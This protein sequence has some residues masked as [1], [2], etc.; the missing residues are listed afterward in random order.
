M[1]KLT[2][3]PSWLGTPVVAVVGEEHPEPGARRPR[4][5]SADQGARRPV[6]EPQRGGGRADEQGGGQDGADGERRQADGD[7]EGGH[8]AMPTRRTGTPR[9]AASRRWSR[10]AARPVEEGDEPR[11]RR[12]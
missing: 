5:H 1:K 9:A 12:R 8:E 10:P 2:G 4:W 6:G 7:G 11:G 3:K